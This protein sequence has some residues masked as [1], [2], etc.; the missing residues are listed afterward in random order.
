MVSAIP[1]ASVQGFQNALYYDQ[2]RPSYP[3]EA[4]ESLLKHLQIHGL[5]GACIVDLAAGT[6]KFTELLAERNEEYEVIAVESHDEMRGELHKKHLKGVRVL[7]GEANDMRGIESH[8]VDAVVASQV[9]R[10]L[11][12]YIEDEEQNYLGYDLTSSDSH[13]IGMQDLHFH[14]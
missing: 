8:S 5:Q 9:P 7:K 4:V 1:S 13:F 12:F 14:I 6:G 3:A 11:P 2:H 10:L